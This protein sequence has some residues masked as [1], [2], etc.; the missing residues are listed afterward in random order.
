MHLFLKRILIFSC[1]IISLICMVEYTLRQVPNVYMYK[2]HLV[3]TKGEKMKNIILGSSV[4]DC[5]MNPE[6]IAVSTYN[7]AIAGQ[8]YR[9]SLAFLEKN[10]DKMPNLKTIVF[11]VCY[12]SFWSDDSPEYDV[13][14]FVSHRIYMGIG[15]SDGLLSHSELLT[16][17]SLSLRK[18]S[19]YYI[20]K[21]CTM[22]C[23]SLGLDNAY[24]SSEK[25]EDWNTDIAEDAISQTVQWE[26]PLM[27]QLFE[28]NE[29]RLNRLAE[30][31]ASRNIRLIFIIP[32]VHSLYLSNTDESQW[33]LVHNA[34]IK[35]KSQWNHISYKDYSHSEDFTDIDFYDGN[36][37]NADIG[38]AKFS[39][40]VKTDFESIFQSC[41]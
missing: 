4:V 14:S 20:R 40:M 8:W 29:N 9:Y 28:E 31:S 10:L 16:S 7:L 35:L 26:E 1:M 41:P 11:G 6:W 15:E 21:K 27:K 12:H 36:H 25:G 2:Q 23:D 30:L 33:R 19:K 17:G 37:L 39:R 32:P 18:W 38:G 34:L 3:D 24:H 5:C 22:Y 13:R